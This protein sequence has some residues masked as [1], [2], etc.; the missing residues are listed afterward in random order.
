M[1]VNT[2]RPTF[3]VFQDVDGTPLDAGYIYIGVPNLDAQA[4]PKAAFFDQS[5][6]TAASQPI[7]TIGGFPRQAGAASRLF[8][9]GN[10]SIKVLDKNQALVYANSNAANVISITDVSG[11][12]ATVAL[13]LAST[14]SAR[15]VGAI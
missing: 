14:E 11:I 13:L 8:V 1:A 6:S 10:Y 4:N 12:Y 2:V 7:R 3:T 9:D 15:G 5:L